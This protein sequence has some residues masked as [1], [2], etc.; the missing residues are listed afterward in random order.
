MPAYSN[1]GVSVHEGVGWLSP[2][3]IRRV[4]CGPLSF[5]M[6]QLGITRTDFWSLDVEAYKWHVLQTFAFAKVDVEV[7]LGYKEGIDIG[8]LEGHFLGHIT[9]HHP[10]SKPRFSWSRRGTDSTMIMTRYT[11]LCVRNI[12]SC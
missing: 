1:T 11:Q 9:P 3:N 2:D 6:E 7:C 10:T 8:H 4:Q 12:L 5:Y